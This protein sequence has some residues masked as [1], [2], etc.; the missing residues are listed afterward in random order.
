MVICWPTMCLHCFSLQSTQ[1]AEL[2][3]KLLRF[4]REIADGMKYLSNKG[5]VH[6]D[7]AA[8]NILLDGKIKCKVSAGPCLLAYLVPLQHMASPSHIAAMHASISVF[9]ILC[10]FTKGMRIAYRTN[11]CAYS[12]YQGHFL[13]SILLYICVYCVYNLV[14]AHCYSKGMAG[15]FLSEYVAV[16]QVEGMTFRPQRSSSVTIYVLQVK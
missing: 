2:P 15:Q 3:H 4:C 1:C 13:S 7:L 11:M 6:R 9:D 12:M 8:R 10:W 16:K 5:F 14:E